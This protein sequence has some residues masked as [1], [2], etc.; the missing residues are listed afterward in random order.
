MVMA[1]SVL[2]LDDAAAADST[3]ALT[4]E[5]TILRERPV[6]N[7]VLA[8]G[9][10]KLD[11]TTTE[12]QGSNV[13]PNEGPG[14]KKDRIPKP[15]VLRP[16][17]APRNTFE[18]RQLW[19]GIVEEVRPRTSE[20]VVTLRALSDHTSPPERGV[21]SLEEVPDSDRGLVAPGAIFYWSI[22]Y[23]RTVSGQKR[24]VSEVRFRRLPS[25]TK[26][27]LRQIRG[28]AEEMARFFG[29]S[30]PNS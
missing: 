18:A 22:G 3:S 15:M 25:W 10:N 27:E 21:L 20:L 23:E 5:Y 11:P 24:S 2:A 9:T 14:R 19:E 7:P 8:G 16:H 26:S 28:E 30:P 12:T 1:Q 4:A 17:Q 29:T 6:E 13:A